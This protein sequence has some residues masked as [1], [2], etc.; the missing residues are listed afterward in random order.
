MRF[1]VWF[2]TLTALLFSTELFAQVKNDRLAVN[3]GIQHSDFY[4]SK[5]GQYGY[6]KSHYAPLNLVDL[7]LSYEMNSKTNLFPSIGI[8]FNQKG[9]T[10]TVIYTMFYDNPGNGPDRKPPVKKKYSYLSVPIGVNYQAPCSGKFSILAGQFIVPEVR[11]SKDEHLNQYALSA[12]TAVA[13]R[14]A[15]NK[16]FGLRLSPWFQT[17][18]TNYSEDRMLSENGKY[19]P[20][21]FGL[22][23]GIDLSK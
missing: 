11:A 20:Y 7:N 4:H 6:H 9:Y 16:T 3:G 12:K 19:L 14:Y 2:V 1:R 21:S 17:A 15:L 8:G 23:L 13:L 22:S 5:D 10:Y 18:L